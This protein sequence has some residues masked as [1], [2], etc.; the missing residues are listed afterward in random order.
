M[1][2]CFS[3]LSAAVLMSLNC[4]SSSDGI[5]R[6]AEVN[7]PDH[8]SFVHVKHSPVC[9]TSL[10]YSFW[11]HSPPGFCRD[12]VRR[13]EDGLQ[14]REQTIVRTC[15]TTS[16]ARRCPQAPFRH[17]VSCLSPPAST[18]WSCLLGAPSCWRDC[19]CRL[20]TVISVLK[21][22]F[23]NRCSSILNTVLHTQ[24]YKQERE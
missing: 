12:A 5:I 24:M 18:E 10:D 6:E 7:T 21:N 15:P 19:P 4:R 20:T 22:I 16:V 9:V 3:V 8:S 11:H 1:Q 17:H 13:S 14:A 2:G 23:C